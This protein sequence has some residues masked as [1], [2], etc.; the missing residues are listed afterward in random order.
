MLEADRWPTTFPLHLAPHIGGAALA[1]ACVAW[2]GANVT[3]IQ[4][5]IN[6]NYE[7]LERKPSYPLLEDLMNSVKGAI[8][9]PRV[10]YEHSPTH[11]RFGSSRVFENMALFSG[12]AT[13]EGVLLQNAVTSPYVYWLQSA[14]SKQDTRVLPGFDYPQLDLARA[15]ARLDLFNVSDMIVVSPEV[16]AALEQDPRW[17]LTLDRSPYAVFHRLGASREYVR[18]P[19]FQP[20]VLK[21]R[22][23][24]R[25][26][27]QWFGQDE[28]LEV[29]L[30]AASMV[31]KTELALFPIAPSLENIP[32]YPIDGDCVIDERIDHLEIEFTTTCPGLPHM[33]AVSFSPNWKVEG[34]KTVFLA[35]P[36]FMLVFPESDRVRLSFGR[37]SSDWAGIVLTSLGFLGLAASLPRRRGSPAEPPNAVTRWLVKLQPYA[38][39]TVLVS[40]VALST[41][42]GVRD[43][44]PPYLY[45]KGWQ[46]FDAQNYAQAQRHFDRV[47]QMDDSTSRAADAA[48][49][50]ALSL[51]R[52]NEH[53]R[54][55]T[56]FERVV[57]EFFDSHW[58]A[59]SHFRIGESLDQLGQTAEAIERFEF[60]KATYPDDRWGQEATER[61]EQM[62]TGNE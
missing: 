31:P 6:W 47:L 62:R 39:V 32:R 61:L 24:K 54:A 57:E 52:A 20:V 51:Q 45:K 21:T 16:K 5:W 42:V 38:T 40:V 30:V 35:S 53:Q 4:S 28:N 33:I 46:A 23:W 14:V 26:F 27:H 19:R 1:L 29:P 7:G 12:R 48:F 37:T 3:F 15:T 13:L 60:L 58:V 17:D 56:G 44:G 2:T 10:G 41:S 49:F 22:D 18:V 59:E 9:D 25:D 8:H 34:A 36:A 11:N 43:F 50:Y 55:V